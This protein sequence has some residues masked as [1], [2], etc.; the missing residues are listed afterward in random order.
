MSTQTL[1]FSALHFNN[2][3]RC[4]TSFFF[5]IIRKMTFTLI[6]SCLPV[7][8]LMLGSSVR[9]AFP[10]L[11]PVIMCVVSIAS[12]GGLF[13]CD[14]HV[15]IQTVRQVVCRFRSCSPETNEST[16]SGSASLHQTRVKR[17]RLPPC[18]KL[19]PSPFCPSPALYP[20]E[21]RGLWSRWWAVGTL[22]APRT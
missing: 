12:A 16:N 4:L 10:S 6:F 5:I 11:V 15:F 19:T 8:C 13:V 22:R 1:K 18:L 14:P 20:S 7:S 2:P 21:R 17:A 3:A 9:T